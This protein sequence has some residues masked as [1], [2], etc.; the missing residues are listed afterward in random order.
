MIY[1]ENAKVDTPDGIANLIWS[2]DVE[3]RMRVMVEFRKD[4]PFR[5]YWQ[6][7]IKKI[8]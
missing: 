5:F 8:K 6:D 2:F 4:Q 3:G 1:K 7:E